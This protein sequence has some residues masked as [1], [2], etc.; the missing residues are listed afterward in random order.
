[1]IRTQV[2]QERQAGRP[3]LEHDPADGAV[4]ERIVLESLPFTIGRHESADLTIASARVSREH[5]V[6]ERHDRG[7]R[8][9][10]LGSTNG[11]LLNGNRIEESAIDDGDVLVIADVEFVFFTG[12]ARA[13]HDTA[14]QVMDFDDDG[15][16]GEPLPVDLVRAVRRLHETLTHRSITNR[17]EPILRLDDR[18]VVGYEAF[19]EETEV[20]TEYD[21]RL[22][23]LECRLTARV[24]QLQRMLAVEEALGFAGA[25]QVFL[26]LDAAELGGER[27]SESLVRLRDALGQRHRLVIGVPDS[28]VS[29]TEYFREFCSGLQE[30]G[31]GLAYDGFAAGP[32]QIEQWNEIRP[33]FLKLARA[34]VRGVDADPKCRRRLEAIVEAGRA[35]GCETI[36]AGI[37]GPAA[38]A[39]CLKAGCRYAQGAWCERPARPA[40]EPAPSS[41]DK[42]AKKEASARR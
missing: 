8:I 21:R 24:R 3:W 23:W 16:G 12:R 1:M 5:A 42:K 2:I 13:P 33:D 9:R 39:A 17:F 26:T 7:Y 14:T 15:E 25:M 40:K 19:G 36:A 31:I 10:D 18:E 29:N 20:R 41:R 32:T 37:D 4:D 28:A 35:I 38:A 22:A 6:I 34:L 27:L 11:T 30:L